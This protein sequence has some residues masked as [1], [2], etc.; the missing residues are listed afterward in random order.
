[1]SRVPERRPSAPTEPSGLNS[2]GL[3]GV[4]IGRVSPF[5]DVNSVLTRLAEYRAIG[6]DLFLCRYA[7]G[8]RP[9][10]HYFVYEGRQY[11]VKAVWAAA[12]NP[13]IHSRTFRTG[14]ALAG[15]AALGFL[16]ELHSRQDDLHNP[17][18]S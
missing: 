12:H 14:E 8:R 4:P 1:M 6:E 2:T 5:P 10:A 13:P 3:S 17:G 9:K 15:L 16:V 7:S 18:H 11:P